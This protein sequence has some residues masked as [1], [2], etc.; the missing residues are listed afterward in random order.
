MGKRRHGDRNI[1][2]FLKIGLLL[3]RYEQVRGQVL[4]IPRERSLEEKGKTNANALR[5]EAV[6]VLRV[7]SQYS[8]NTVSKKDWEGS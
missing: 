1:S 7:K 4:E 5:I 2:I 8:Q 6:D 3:L